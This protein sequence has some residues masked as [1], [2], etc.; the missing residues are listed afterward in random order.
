MG[1]SLPDEFLN[2][3]AETI[4]VLGHPLRLRIIEILDIKGRQSQQELVDQLQCQQAAAS[5]HLTK[6]KQANIIS[7]ERCGKQ[8][9][10]EISAVSATTILN[11]IRNKYKTLSSKIATEETK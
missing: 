10:Y 8:V 6:M 2:Y 5:Q 9:F 11:C 7:C 3:V 4:K 1:K